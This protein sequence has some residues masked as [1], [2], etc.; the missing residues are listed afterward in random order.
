MNGS[1]SRVKFVVIAF[2]LSILFAQVWRLPT[3]AADEAGAQ[4]DT[5]QWYRLTNSFLGDDFALEAYSDAPNSLYMGSTGNFSGQ[6]WKFTPLGDGYYRMTSQ[7]FGDGRSLD[8]YSDT[9]APF[10][11]D[12]G[13]YSGQYWKLISLGNGYFRLSNMFLGEERS[14]DTY[15]DTHAPF[16][17]Q[18]GNYS[19]QF[20]KLTPLGFS[21][22]NDTPTT[23]SQDEFVPTEPPIL[24]DGNSVEPDSDSFCIDLALLS[25]EIGFSGSNQTVCLQGDPATLVK[26]LETLDADTCAALV[27]GPRAGDI[28]VFSDMA[29]ELGATVTVGAGYGGSVLV[30]GT[31]EAGFVIGPDGEAGCY[32]SQCFGAQTDVQGSIFE[33][34]GI[35]TAWDNVPGR[36]IV[37]SQ[38][39]SIPLVEAGYTSAQV[40]SS[41]NLIGTTFTLST[42]LGVLPVGVGGMACTTST[43]Q[44]RP[45]IAYNAH[46]GL[47]TRQ[48]AQAEVDRL[49]D[50]IG[51]LRAT[52]LAERGSHSQQIRDAQATV[53]AEQTK[54]NQLGQEIVQMRNTVQAERNRDAAELQA[55]QNDVHAAQRDVDSLYADIDS[56]Q[57][58]IDQINRDI[59]AKK[60]WLDGK[61]W[62]D[63]V[64]AGPE[65][66]AFA[67][68]K[69][70][71]Q[72]GL[73]TKIAGLEVSLKTATGALE[74]AKGA[75]HIMEASVD[76]FPIEADPRLA[77]LYAARDTALVTLEGA[78]SA[79]SGADDISN[80]PPV[81]SDP[82][83]IELYIELGLAQAE[84][85]LV[86]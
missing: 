7:A 73:Y 51:A 43:V 38:N 14:L 12:S 86:D 85:D 17:G 76:T 46:H 26:Q 40:L 74:T 27:G 84:L 60:R 79:L 35:Y 41:G 24:P 39:A 1:T 6:Y 19:G 32:V 67:S 80:A 71:E 65:Y 4:I 82:R 13:N 28:A 16:M 63:K 36:S 47:R 18:S 11:G 64:W 55:A 50:E 10:M 45:T 53:E 75:L 57:A 42:G 77:A 54:V 62:V 25:A 58:Q 3:V 23:P 31:N 68:A 49:N 78:K 34:L 29:R 37:T 70:I 15:S 22:V 56:A 2:L 8:T 66:A 83:M 5:D 44:I 30:G 48:Q 20:W 33:S 69:R 72:A 59:T 61:S 52:I 9:H 21:A 81:E